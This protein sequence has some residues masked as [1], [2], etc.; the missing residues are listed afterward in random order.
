MRRPGPWQADDHERPLDP[1]GRDLGM[2]LSRRDHTETILEETRQVRARNDAPEQGQLRLALEPVEQHSE[3][4]AKAVVPEVVE[5]R[6]PG[7]AREQPVGVEIEQ[8]K[9]DAAK[10]LPDA[11]QH[12][13]T[14][15]TRRQI[16][17]RPRNRAHAGA[18]VKA[19][20]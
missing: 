1:P 7:R 20:A 5:P 15:R 18:E 16:A 8:R 4:L 13:D 19:S 17:H 2:L 3:R 10:R 14:E 6:R 11:V 9:P 12:T